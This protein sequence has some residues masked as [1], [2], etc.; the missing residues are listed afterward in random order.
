MKLGLIARAD[1]RGLGTLTWQV[2]RH[3]NPE[4]TLV[5]DMGR[6]SPMPM[7]LD[8]YPG[9]TVVKFDGHR[10][11]PEATVREW[12]AGLDVIYS[13]E[14]LYDWRLAGWAADASVGTVVHAMPEFYRH[15]P[16]NPD[17]P[18]PTAWWVPTTWRQDQVPGARLVP[19]PCPVDR[20]PTLE[21]WQRAV[22]DP[23]RFLH[24]AGKLAAWDRNGTRLLLQALR[25]VTVPVQVT[26]WTQDSQVPRQLRMP[27]HVDLRIVADDRPEWWAGY[28]DHDVLLLPRRYGGL[29]LPALE[30]A[31]AGLALVMPYCSPNG[32]LPLAAGI[33]TELGETVTMPCGPVRLHNPS[34]RHLAQIISDLAR[35][36]HDVMTGQH[37]ARLWAEASGW[38]SPA[39]QLWVE[40]LA[41]A[42]DW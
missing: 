21:L 34:A 36:P 11:T 33:A 31:A 7:H 18:H 35:S 16:G 4:R 26:I 6:L 37:H 1:N 40:E 8:R 17:W 19:V 23:V 30:A 10:L 3:L 38:G 29:C 42:G 12:I 5:V 25:Y 15:G 27:A 13:A 39:G 20:F 41:E 28:T 24:T 9:A 32:E 14:T 2:H 22:T